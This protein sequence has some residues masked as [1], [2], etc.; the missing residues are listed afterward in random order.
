MSRFLCFTVYILSY[1]VDMEYIAN[2]VAFGRFMH[3]GDPLRHICF[4]DP[5]GV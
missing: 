4:I 2:I 3:F 5:P 1:S